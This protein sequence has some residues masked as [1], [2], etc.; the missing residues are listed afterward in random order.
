[1][2]ATDYT[3]L[4]YTVPDA[5]PLDAKSVPAFSVG[6]KG[7]V[8][9]KAFVG[10]SK[11]HVFYAL[12]ILSNSNELVFWTVLR[13]YIPLTAVVMLLYWCCTGGCCVMMLYV[14]SVVPHA[15][16]QLHC[17]REIA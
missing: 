1:M 3:H 6:L 8:K 9:Q 7:W 5:A 14:L 15:C 16:M 12:N 11:D 17:L 4:H 13:R 2:I 10:D